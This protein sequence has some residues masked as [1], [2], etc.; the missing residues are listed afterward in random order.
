MDINDTVTDPPQTSHEND[1]AAEE[2]TAPVKVTLAKCGMDCTKCRF[3]EENDCPGC[4][5]GHLFEDEEC[6]VYN[7][8]TEKKYPHCGHCPDFPCE[9]LKE[10]SFDTETGDGGERLMRLKDI[11]DRDYRIKRRRYASLGTGICLGIAL[12][13][14]IGGLSGDLGIWLFGGAVIGAGFG[15]IIGIAGKNR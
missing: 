8:C 13:A 2:N 11:R 5:Q 15:G 7:C 14:V 12:G 9:S 10:T 3:A 6:E 4:M 1:G